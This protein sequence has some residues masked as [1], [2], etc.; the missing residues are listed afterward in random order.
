ML[1]LCSGR[2]ASLGLCMVGAAKLCVCVCVF[3]KRRAPLLPLIVK[4]WTLT[5]EVGLEIL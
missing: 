4:K 3:M 5:H 2:G 1:R